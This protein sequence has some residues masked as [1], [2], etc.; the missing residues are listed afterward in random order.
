MHV[1]MHAFIIVFVSSTHLLVVNWTAE[2]RLDIYSN[3]VDTG[4]RI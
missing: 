3:I 4:I 2:E 1:C